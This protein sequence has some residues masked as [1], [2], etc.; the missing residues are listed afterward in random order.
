MQRIA[1]PQMRNSQGFQF[2]PGRRLPVVCRDGVT[3][4][5]VITGQ[6]DTFFSIPA[7]V[8]ITSGGKRRTVS[9]SLYQDIDGKVSFGAYRYRANAALIPWTSHK[10][11]LAKLARKLIAA[12]AYGKAAEG[13]PSDHAETLA[14]ICRTEAAGLTEPNGQESPGWLVRRILCR[15]WCEEVERLASFFER[16]ARFQSA[17]GE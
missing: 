16:L 2:Y 15:L 10:P 5:A 3:R 13:L 4:A 9:G 8:Q 17:A 6:P 12:T 1:P 7:A 14:D 11:R